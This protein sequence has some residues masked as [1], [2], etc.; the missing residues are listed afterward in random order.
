MGDEEYQGTSFVLGAL[1]GLD[2]PIS[3][4]WSLQMA[5][6]VNELVYPK[7]SDGGLDL[8]WYVKGAL[9]AAYRF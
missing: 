2:L 1:V 4:G 9:G 8:S 3:H 6:E 5:W 7:A